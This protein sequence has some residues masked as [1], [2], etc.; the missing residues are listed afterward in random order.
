MEDKVQERKAESGRAGEEDPD[1]RR[2]RRPGKISR[3]K[4]YCFTSFLYLEIFT[5]PTV[6][7]SAG[8]FGFPDHGC[9]LRLRKFGPALP[10]SKRNCVSSRRAGGLEP[11]VSRGVERGRRPASEHTGG[12]Q[13][14]GQNDR[15]VRNL[16]SFRLV[17]G[18]C[19]PMNHASLYK[20]GKK[21][22]GG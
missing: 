14:Q 19:V 7:R 10:M 8:S 9:R 2:S 21:N 4:Y 3:G 13:G 5:I 11:K 17:L 1:R 6:Q 12:G 20:M 15:M 18:M 16:R 22:Q